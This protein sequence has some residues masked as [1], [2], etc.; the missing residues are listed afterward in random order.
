MFARYIIKVHPLLAAPPLPVTTLFGG[1][2]RS[3]VRE[4]GHNSLMH[5]MKNR[6]EA[7]CDPPPVTLF[8][9]PRA[10]AKTALQR[11]NKIYKATVTTALQHAA[12][13]VGTT[14]DI[15]WTRSKVL[16]MASLDPIR[17]LFP[18]ATREA[19]LANFKASTIVEQAKG[20]HLV[21]AYSGEQMPSIDD[22]T[23]FSLMQS[24]PAA[25]LELTRSDYDSS[26]RGWV[27]FC[28]V[29]G[30][31]AR[32]F[33]AEK[34]LLMVFVAQLLLC[35]Y[36]PATIGK[37]LSAIITRH[38]T[39][40]HP[41]PFLFKELG[42]WVKGLKKNVSTKSTVKFPLTPFHL[43]TLARL[44]TTTIEE[45]RNACMVLVGTVGACGQS[46]IVEL[47]VCDWLTGKELF[48]VM[49]YIKRQKND[50]MGTGK[51]KRFST[52]N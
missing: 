47:D 20:G 17:H 13:M 36:A 3:T 7:L 31:S 10:D 14:A 1:T 15:Q 6:S 46:E 49:A 50:V 39:F 5:A 18:P 51:F 44:P 11:H 29:M 8:E 2:S 27:T 12:A 40:G 22:L 41:S 38:S 9:R 4:T 26:W 19:V 32:A 48:G 25:L 35:Q 52:G 24:L 34:R 30:V 33:P 37:I 43:Q 28:I 42:N 45:E 16:T 23:S 21:L